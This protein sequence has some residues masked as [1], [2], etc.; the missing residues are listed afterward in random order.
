MWQWRMICI[1]TC[2]ITVRKSIFGSSDW[3]RTAVLGMNVRMDEGLVMK[4]HWSLKGVGYY[5]NTR[6][7]ST[8]SFGGE[9]GGRSRRIELGCGKARQRIGTWK[10]KTAPKPII[11]ISVRHPDRGMNRRPVSPLVFNYTH[12]TDYSPNRYWR[13][14]K[15]NAST[16]CL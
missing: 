9:E 16:Q 11:E 3:R 14:F 7:R 4:S 13:T 6:V 15:N 2:E 8:L 12:R 10:N 5:I 1:S